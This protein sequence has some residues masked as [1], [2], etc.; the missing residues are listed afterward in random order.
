METRYLEWICHR[1]CFT[2]CTR[3]KN[4]RN[5][6]T[7]WK[8]EQLPEFVARLR[9]TDEVAVESRATR[10]CSTR[11][12]AAREARGRGEPEPV[13]GDHASVSKTDPNDARNLALYL[14]KDLLPEVR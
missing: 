10:D 9:P 13:P 2:A 4:G 14:A 3:L 7:Q 6:V 12:G 5:Y 8:L 1:N 11:G